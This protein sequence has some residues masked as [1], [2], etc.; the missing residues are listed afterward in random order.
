MLKNII[1]TI[2]IIIIAVAI[3]VVVVS[4]SRNEL[5]LIQLGN[6]ILAEAESNVLESKIVTGDL[7]L[8]NAEKKEV[9]EKD[10]ITYFTLE[11]QKSEIRTNQIAAITKDVNGV[12]IY[13]LKKEDGTIENIDDSC[14]IGTYELSIP[15][16]GKI[17][18]YILSKNGFLTVTLIPAIILFIIMLLKFL[19]EVLPKKQNIRP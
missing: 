18:N 3:G 2:Y 15:Y 7:I 11:N 5:G 12:T 4:M 19:T 9:K 8:V 1:L 6:I 17:L 10:I 13:S 16:A 14:I